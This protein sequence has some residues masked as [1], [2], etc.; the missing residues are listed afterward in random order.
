MQTYIWYIWQNPHYSKKE[1]PIF[2]FIQVKTYI[3]IHNWNDLDLYYKVNNRE[4]TL[5]LLSTIRIIGTSEK[6][7]INVQS[8]DTLMNMLPTLINCVAIDDEYEYQRDLYF[9]SFV[10]PTIAYTY[11]NKCIIH[12]NYSW[13]WTQHSYFIVFTVTDDILIGIYMWYL[14]FFVIKQN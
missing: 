7:M 4:V 8:I 2:I 14:G 12:H 10:E 11:P 9:T 1:N 3:S 6:N 5:K 13:Y